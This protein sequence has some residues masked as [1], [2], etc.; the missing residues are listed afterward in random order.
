MMIDGCVSWPDADARRY[1][2][3]GYWTGE[4]LGSL[5]RPIAAADPDRVALVTESARVRYGE[6]DHWADRVAAGLADLGI[7]PR[8][9]V[10]V[11]LP[12]I[13]E[14][15]AFAIACFRLGAL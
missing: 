11:Q 10:V 15:A 5:L 4:T 3:A 9:R 14:F 7:A 8:D 13:P 2:E 6:L 1:R 12:N